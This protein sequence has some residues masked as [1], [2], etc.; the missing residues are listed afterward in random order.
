MKLQ[1]FVSTQRRSSAA[2]A[3]LVVFT[4]LMA[5]AQTETVIHAFQ[6]SKNTM[7]LVLLGM[8]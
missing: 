6:S 1:D 5:T 4:S 8:A 7:A 2:F 3:A